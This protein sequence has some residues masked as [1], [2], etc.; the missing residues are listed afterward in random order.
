MADKITPRFTPRFTDAELN[1]VFA[2]SRISIDWPGRWST[3]RDGRLTIWICW[4]CDI[5]GSWSYDEIS[6]IAAKLGTTRINFHY[7]KGW[8]GTE[9][10]PGDDPTCTISIEWEMS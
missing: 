10:T 3:R 4:T 9:V 6:A 8:Y 7:A 5:E 1:D 2:T